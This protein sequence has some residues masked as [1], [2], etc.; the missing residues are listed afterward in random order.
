MKTK[1]TLLFAS[2]VL[3]N[4]LNISAQV[5]NS[6]MES[7]T[8]GEPDSWHTSNVSTIVVPVTQVTPAHSGAYAA[9]GEVVLFSG[10]PY[11]T[12]LSSTDASLNGFAITQ[13]FASFSFYYKMLV[14]GTTVFEATATL[15]DVS[16]GWVAD[17]GQFI[18]PGTVSSYTQA[19]FAFNYGSANAPVECVILFSIHDTLGGNPPVG[20]YF[21]VDDITLSGTVGIAYNTP[22]NYF[23]SVFPNPAKDFVSVS[24]SNA[25]RGNAEI[26]V[27]DL[28]GNVV[29]KLCSTMNSGERF[30]QKFSVADLPAGIYPVRITAGK[31]QWMAKIVKD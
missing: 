11:N 5:P 16:G 30:E 23:A 22:G 24:V 12:V 15:Y 1:I 9:K 7:W 13:S 19:N 14:T 20:N 28:L 31:S 18:Q 21:I 8:S 3:L 4:A 6:G 29:K 25:I 10:S 17:A 27:Y 26:V 2:T